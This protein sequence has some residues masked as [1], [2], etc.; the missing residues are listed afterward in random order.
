MLSCKDAKIDR[1]REEE[2]GLLSN[3]QVNQVKGFSRGLEIVKDKS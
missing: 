2:K 3:Q 1:W